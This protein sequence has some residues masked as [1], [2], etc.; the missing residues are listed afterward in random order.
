MLWIRSLDMHAKI[1]YTSDSNIFTYLR[2]ENNKANIFTYLRK[3]NNKAN[4]FTY[5]RKENNK[6][7]AKYCFVIR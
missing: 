2:K 6:L 5:L 3:E 7:D 1:P 4:I